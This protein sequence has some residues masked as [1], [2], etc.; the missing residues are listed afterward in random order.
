[1]VG[2]IIAQLKNQAQSAGIDISDIEFEY[3]QN[4]RAD[5]PQSR[6]KFIANMYGKLHQH[7]LEKIK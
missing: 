4:L 2:E 3:A 7:A 6:P 1:M 5:N